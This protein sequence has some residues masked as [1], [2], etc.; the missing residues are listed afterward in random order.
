MNRCVRMRR[1]QRSLMFILLNLFIALPVYSSTDEALQA[2]YAGSALY[3]VYRDD[4]L[5]GTHTLH[6]AEEGDLLRV[7]AEM[8][9]Q[10]RFLG[11]F[12]YRYLYQATERWH[13]GELQSLEV[14]VNDDGKETEIQMQRQ[15]DVL[16]VSQ[17]GKTHEIEIEGT[18]L[19]TNHWNV[20]IL[21]QQQVIN[22]L[23]GRLSTLNVE[24]IGEIEVPRGADER[25]IVPHYRLGGDLKD[26]E[27]W[28][29]ED[30]RWLGME[31]SARD[32]SR[33]RVLSRQIGVDR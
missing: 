6:F 19:T 33:I 24:R 21:S 8:N 32:R 7:D 10:I 26:T 5:I 28:Y 12:N 9:L 30:G 18:L 20:D 2:R 29:D 16:R 25:V 1:W 22:T 31:F 27:T 3:D 14:R 17:E 23:T 11:M 4:R 15:G 13:K